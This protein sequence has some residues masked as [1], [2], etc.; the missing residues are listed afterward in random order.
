MSSIKDKKTYRK[1][2]DTGMTKEKAARI[3]NA[4]ADPDRAP[5][6]KGGHAPAYEEWTKDDLYARAQDL[7]VENRS[8]MSKADLIAALRDR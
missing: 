5:F 6:K 7:S 4:N 3:A 2:R 1:L 8:K